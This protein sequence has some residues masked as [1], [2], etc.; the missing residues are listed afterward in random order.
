KC[1]RRCGAVAIDELV[2]DRRR[3][4]ELSFEYPG[5]DLAGVPGGCIRNFLAAPVPRGAD[6]RITAVEPADEIELSRPSRLRDAPA[7]ETTRPRILTAS[8]QR[9]GDMLPAHEIMQRRQRALLDEKEAH[10]DM[11]RP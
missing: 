11:L 1:D 6:G 8:A 4:V 9:A 2:A 3:P 5:R 10:D 7:D